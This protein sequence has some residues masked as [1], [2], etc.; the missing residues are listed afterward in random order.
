MSSDVEVKV[1]L[2]HENA[3]M[4]Y[5]SHDGDGCMDI[6]AVD[7][8]MIEGDGFGY[9]EYSTGLS[10][11]FPKGY[12]MLAFP[13]SSV[14]NTGLIL[15]NA[16]GVID[17]GYRGE[18]KARFKYVKGTAMYDPGDR[19]FQ[20]MLVARPEMVMKQVDELGTSERSKGGF[21]STGK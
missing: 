19:I 12:V 4:P 11:E 15:S 6:T 9:I 17:H 3:V 21:G 10:F 14:S 1:K 16:V 5:Y 13:R 20:I 18:I 2:L 7:V 8:H